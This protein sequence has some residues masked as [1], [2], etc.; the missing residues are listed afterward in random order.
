VL[1]TSLDF[2]LQRMGRIDSPL[3]TGASESRLPM[4]TELDVRRLFVGGEAST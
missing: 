2:R 1:K 3:F 4:L